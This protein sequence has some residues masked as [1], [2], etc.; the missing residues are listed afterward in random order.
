MNIRRYDSGQREKLIFVCLNGL[1]AY[2]LLSGKVHNDRVYQDGL[3]VVS[4][5]YVSHSVYD[6]C[7]RQHTSLNAVCSYSAEERLGL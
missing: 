5:K 4:F 7:T 6:F 1:V 3:L 2:Q